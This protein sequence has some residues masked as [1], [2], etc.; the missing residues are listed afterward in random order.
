MPQT[1]DDWQQARRLRLEML[2][3]SPKSFLE[4]LRDARK[5]P[6]AAWRTR[7]RSACALDSVGVAVVDSDGVWRGQMRARIFGSPPPARVFLLAVYLSPTVRGQGI[8]EQLLRHI[9]EW[10][11][12]RGFTSLTLEVHEQAHA[13]RR[14]Y[15]KV[16]FVDTGERV[17]YP[18]CAGEY[19]R[20]MR[21]DLV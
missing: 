14:F 15:A 18:L 11:T 19:E 9:T 1:E 3:D 13:A 10:T 7:Q 6:D 12:A 2:A 20:A 5:L 21:L 4:T 17:P 16:G 8:A